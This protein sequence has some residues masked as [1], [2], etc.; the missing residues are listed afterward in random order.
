MI[1]PPGPRKVKSGRRFARQDAGISF[2]ETIVIQ[3]NVNIFKNRLAIYFR[4]LN[5]SKKLLTSHFTS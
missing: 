5:I 2:T 1:R 3:I 4:N